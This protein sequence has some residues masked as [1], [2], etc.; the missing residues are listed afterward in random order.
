MLCI[1][2]YLGGTN[3]MNY[4]SFGLTVL[5][6]SKGKF[7]LNIFWDLKKLNIW[8]FIKNISLKKKKDN[9]SGVLF[10][11]FLMFL[12]FFYSAS[13]FSLLS[14]A[15]FSLYSKFSLLLQH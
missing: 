9:R 3:I 11:F 14:C 6:F 12:P 1:E 13:S 2:L 15:S 5:N 10:V 4:V 8:S 7:V